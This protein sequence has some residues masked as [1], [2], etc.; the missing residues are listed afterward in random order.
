MTVRL[1]KIKELQNGHVEIK[2]NV[3]I[4]PL[5]TGSVL[6]DT[7]SSKETTDIPGVWI[8]NYEGERDGFGLYS[9]RGVAMSTYKNV[10]GYFVNVSGIDISIT[11][12]EYTMI[13]NIINRTLKGV[14]T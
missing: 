1:N 3:Y 10:N 13:N 2:E 5:S 6:F 12:K 8:P 4:F 11:P 7:L 14:V 9:Y